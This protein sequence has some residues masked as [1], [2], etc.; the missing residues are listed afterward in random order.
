L[1]PSPILLAAGLALLL[2]AAA[3]AARPMITD[4]ARITD[5]HACQIETWTKATRAGREYWAFPACNPTGNFE[6]TLGGNSLPDGTG[7]H[8]GDYLLQGKTL[9]RPLET[10]GYAWGLAAGIIRHGDPM[11]GQGRTSATYFYLPISASFMDDRLVVHVN[12]G[13]QN[14]RDAG[15]RPVTYGLGSEITVNPRFVLI[16][17]TYGDEN[18]RQYYHAGVR[19]WVVPGRFQI[20]ATRGVQ[21]GDYGGSRWWTIG[22]RIISPAFMK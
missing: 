21:A 1:K 6:F 2:S 20:D 11:V 9:F 15:T 13:A 14:N 8:V 12:V 22:L 5:A 17:E 10:N 19:I 3:H 18:T 7:G 16:A 4:D